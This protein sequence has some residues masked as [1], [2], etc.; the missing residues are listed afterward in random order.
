M[1][2]FVI[3]GA[4]PIGLYSTVVARESGARTIIVVGAPRNRLELAKKWGADHVIDIE[5]VPDA[6][7]RRK[8]ILSLHPG[9]RP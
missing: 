2:D 1:T 6:E 9:P 3:Q 4:G 5:E 7:E 8:M